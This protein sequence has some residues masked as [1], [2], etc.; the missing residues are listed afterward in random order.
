MYPIAIKYLKF[1]YNKKF[2][3]CNKKLKKCE[4]SNLYN[5]RRDDS[6]SMSEDFNSSGSD[7]DQSDSDSD[8]SL[9]S[10]IYVSDTK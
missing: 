5:F 6:D 3:A 9:S 10:S 1:K 7:E 2:T 8:S 4:K